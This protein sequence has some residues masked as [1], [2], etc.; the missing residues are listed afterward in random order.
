M[1]DFLLSAAILLQQTKTASVEL[2]FS[3]D[4][5]D[6]SAVT[7]VKLSMPNDNN[8][9]HHHMDTDSDTQHDD[10]INTP[11][12]PATPD[13]PEKPNQQDDSDTPKPIEKTAIFGDIDSD[14]KITS[15]DA[16]FVLRCSVGLKDNTKAGET[17]VLKV[18]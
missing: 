2:Y 14:G 15:G 11:D 12:V 8:S 3:V 9:G 6:L 10:T 4:E 17:L 18:S 1:T 13:T 7:T 16:L 5:L